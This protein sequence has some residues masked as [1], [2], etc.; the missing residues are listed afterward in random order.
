MWLDHCSSTLDLPVLRPARS[1]R[2]ITM[3][4]DHCG[5]SLVLLQ[6]PAIYS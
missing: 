5:S 2:F 6:R 4:L 3:W 1:R